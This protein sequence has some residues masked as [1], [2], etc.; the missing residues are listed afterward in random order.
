MA[1]EAAGNSG[2]KVRVVSMMCR[3]LFEAQDTSFKT[4]LIPSGVRVITAEAGVGTG[5][6]GIASSEEDILCIDRFGESGPA[7]AVAD[8]LGINTAALIT[9]IG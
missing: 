1:I 7:P 2:K 6:R 8:A 3:E 4:T 5:W 9:L